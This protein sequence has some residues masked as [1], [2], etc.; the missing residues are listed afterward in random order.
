MA[1]S[2]PDVDA[3]AG[4][5]KDESKDGSQNGS[6]KSSERDEE[7]EEEEEPKARSDTGVSTRG[8]RAV[9]ATGNTEAKVTEAAEPE[10]RRASGSSFPAL[11]RPSKK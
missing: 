8:R 3:T 1:N 4:T 7:E 5:A 6:V 2:S 9:C 11:F 10:K